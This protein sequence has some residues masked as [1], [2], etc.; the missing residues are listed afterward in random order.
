MSTP[1]T[2][3][4]IA[5]AE[6]PRNPSLSDCHFYHTVTFPD[7]TTQPGHWDLRTCID[8]YFGQ[9]DLSGRSFLDVGTA[10]GF[11]SFSAE[12]RGASP[13]ISVDAAS[14]TRLRPIPW[15]EDIA[16]H[17][18]D[19]HRTLESVKNSYWYCH[20]AFSSNSLV[21]YRDVYDLDNSLG[22][23]DVVIAGCILLH[24]INP[25]GALIQIAR[26]AAHTLIITELDPI[27]F[28]DQPVLLPNF[29][30]TRKRT[31]ND[32]MSWWQLP[33][34]AISLFL[35]VMGFETLRVTKF[36]MPSPIMNQTG[37]FYSLVAQ[38]RTTL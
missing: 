35:D 30:R 20:R 21:I 26:R 9:V 10:T 22:Q 5:A 8:D 29:C 37:H 18:I 19:C 7:G 11:L 32:L 2:K 27:D 14:D 24:L 36:D 16:D 34:A 28:G 13:V 25:I 3:F 4:L 31:P 33:S 15:A 38:R 6:S 1:L 23:F 12:D 17:S